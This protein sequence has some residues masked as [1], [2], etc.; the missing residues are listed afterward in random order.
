MG[1]PE[2]SGVHGVT[3]ASPPVAGVVLAA[4]SSTRMGKNKL[5]LD[6]AGETVVR[7]AVRTAADAGLD[8]VVVVLGHEAARVEAELV[9]LA[10]RPV[11]NP[12]HAEGVRT[13]LQLG[14][15]EVAADAHALVVVLADMPFVTAAMIR[16]VVLRHRDTGAPLV[17]SQ[18]GVGSAPGAP[19]VEGLPVD[20][21]PIL[22][23]RTLFAELLAMKGEHCA[24][25]IVRQHRGEA[26]I[27][28]WAEHALRDIDVA[29]DYEHARAH[30]A[31][32]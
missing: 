25:R 23:D 1:P 19:P 9:G 24:K 11:V 26:S 13:S 28:V 8:P 10:C 16:A 4:G 20:A 30:V 21:P 17:V 29:A 31:R 27:V 12:D 14:V 6:L 2:Q 5:L 32:G 18:Y 15:R 22:Y 3:V 7:R